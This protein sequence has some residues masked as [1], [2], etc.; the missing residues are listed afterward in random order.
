[1]GKIKPGSKDLLVNIDGQWPP[2]VWGRWEQSA[3]GKYLV[4]QWLSG[5]DYSGALVTK[6]NH[7]AWMEKFP[8]GEDKW[9]ANI[10]GGHG[11]YA[12][13]IAL[14]KVPEDVE[15][16]VVEV[17]DSLDSYPLLD[18]DLHSQM[19]M[20]SQHEAWKDWGRSDFKRALE[21]KFPD[22]DI[23]GEANDKKV[24]ELFWEKSDKI[25][26][27]W[28]NEEGSSSYINVEKVAKTVSEKE[29]NEL[30]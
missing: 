22:L 14:E 19:E 18:E 11:T 29:A 26:E 20:E 5:S 25:G 16:E 28:V 7:Q 17:F 15:E 24:D 1:M 8:E 23:T 2:K 9:W 6:S 13:V 12:I 4:P 21:K 27:Y 10:H 30:F 3:S